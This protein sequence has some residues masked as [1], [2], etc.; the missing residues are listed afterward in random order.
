MHHILYVL[1]LMLM[2]APAGLHGQHI[3]WSDMQL[4]W[5]D[6]RG[7]PVPGSRH[8]AESHCVMEAQ[9]EMENGNMVFEVV[10]YFIP[11]RSWSRNTNSTDLLQHE[12][13][14]F[15]LAEVYTRELRKRLSRLQGSNRQIAQE[16]RQLFNQL[17]DELA[18]AQQRY[19]QETRH[20]MYQQAQV[21]WEN[22]V[23]QRLWELDNYRE[24][25]VET[26]NRQSFE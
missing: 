20:G 18:R 16:F 9:S 24:T 22:Y 7:T 15:D 17:N 4:T 10:C 11:E 19:D 1:L 5:A 23:R 2:V 25:R 6:F 3:A 14:H 13:L 26:M 8:H 12:Q 21:R